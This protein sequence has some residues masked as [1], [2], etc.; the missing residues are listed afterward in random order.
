MESELRQLPGEGICVEL[1]PEH[2]RLFGYMDARSWGDI[3]NQTG[4]STLKLRPRKLDQPLVSIKVL[5]GLA[6]ED[7]LV[8]LFSQ[9]ASQF[10]NNRGCFVLNIALKVAT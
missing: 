6:V 8:C 10:R 5:R 1:P 9:G 3:S 7:T 2:S 4:I